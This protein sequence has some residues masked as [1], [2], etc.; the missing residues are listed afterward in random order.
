MPVVDTM[1]NAIYSEEWGTSD[2]VWLFGACLL[3][4]LYMYTLLSLFKLGNKSWYLTLYS[5]SVT[6]VFGVYFAY[7]CA[8]EG[9]VKVAVEEQQLAREC[10][11][12]TFESRFSV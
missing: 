2:E 11:D 4:C 8:Q 6:T 7:R 12:Y 10:L 1:I 9:I 3:G 5:S